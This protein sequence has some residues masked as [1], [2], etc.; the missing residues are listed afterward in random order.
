MELFDK[1]VTFACEKH[2]G[3]LRKVTG[4]PY[5]LHPMEVA[6]IVGTM[7]SDQNLLSA[8]ILH[9][10]VEDTDTTM[11]EIKELFGERVEQLV[12]TE[13]EDKR[14]D[15]PA[16]ETW[17][18]RKEESLSDLAEADDMDVKM[19]WLGDKL[20]NIRSLCTA[21]KK[22]GDKLWEN[23]NQ[24]DPKEHEWYYR[25]VKKAL[26]E[27]EEYDAYKEFSACIDELFGKETV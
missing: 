1:A 19:L 5:F 2:S 24:K 26:A 3:Q 20:S 4:A 15:R 6:T 8:A 9:D 13:T 17:R 22:S 25:E 23:F 12:K 10:T 16:S 27:L 7:S 21:Y 11:E 18:I 14:K